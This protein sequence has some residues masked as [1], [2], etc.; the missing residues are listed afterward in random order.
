MKIK[1]GQAVFVGSILV[2]SDGGQI[3]RNGYFGLTYQIRHNDRFVLALEFN[4]NISIKSIPC[5]AGD[6]KRYLLKSDKNTL[7]RDPGG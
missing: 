5:W 3:G 1:D 4:F 2:K 7:V 6:L